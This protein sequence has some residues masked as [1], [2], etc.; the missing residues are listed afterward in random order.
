ME[1]C[2]FRFFWTSWT[3]EWC[4]LYDSWVS[5]Y[6]HSRE[7]ARQQSDCRKPVEPFPC[8]EY[9]NEYDQ[10]VAGSKYLEN[11]ISSLSMKRSP[12]WVCMPLFFAL[13]VPVTARAENPV[14]PPCFLYE[15]GIASHLVTTRNSHF[16]KAFQAHKKQKWKRAD[17]LF[18]K[19]INQ[20]VK[21]GV[22][23]FQ[24]TPDTEISNKQI[25]GFLTQY[26]LKKNP[27]ILVGPADFRFAPEIVLAT[28][29][30]RCKNGN[31]KGALAILASSKRQ[32]HLHIPLARAVISLAAGEP[33][34]A[35][36]ELEH[37]VH[38]D[39]WRGRLVRAQALMQLHRKPEAKREIESALNSCIGPSQCALV[40]KVY[41]AL[42]QQREEV[43]P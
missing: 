42:F 8:P 40:E 21:Q 3:P 12:I 14:L 19:K 36:S 24:A 16:R 35:L 37:S 10:T 4:Y 39:R 6:H 18:S 1:V 23:I 17:K 34:S 26:V 20:I 11:S 29:E 22:N 30:A 32:D 28:A 31:S 33:K 7:V 2:P 15:A 43:V 5:V 9:L 27:T 41:K 25:Q 13:L 38:G